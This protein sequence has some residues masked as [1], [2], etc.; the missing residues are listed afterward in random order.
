MKSILRFSL[1]LLLAGVAS[2]LFAQ[3]EL[4]HTTLAAAVTTPSATSVRLTSASGVAVNSTVLIIDQEVMAVVAISGTTI[5]V[6]RGAAGTRANPHANAA[7]VTISVAQATV[8]VQPVGPCTQGTVYGAGAQPSDAYEPIFD[9][10]DG[11]W[12]RCRSSVWNGSST[13][14]LTYNSSPY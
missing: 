7:V 12:W 5:T 11:T 8:S 10:V 14:K 4:T 3:T 9:T 13:Q 1:A 2:P 6:Q